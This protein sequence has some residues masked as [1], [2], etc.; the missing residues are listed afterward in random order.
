MRAI[1]VHEP[2]LQASG[3]RSVPGSTDEQHGRLPGGTCQEDFRGS[4]PIPGVRHGAPAGTQRQGDDP[5][6]QDEVGDGQRTGDQSVVRCRSVDLK[7]EGPVSCNSCSRP[8]RCSVQSAK[9]DSWQEGRR[10]RGR[11]GR[12]CL[13]ETAGRKQALRVRGPPRRGRRRSS[14]SR[15]PTS[16]GA[17]YICSAACRSGWRQRRR[18]D[19]GF[20]HGKLRGQ[21]FRIAAAHR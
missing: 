21:P 19:L 14:A 3:S 13:R 2:G 7:G 20:A 11:T 18:A 9:A 16:P 4:V 15:R 10:R 12:R 17:R 8:C 1:S 5:A 6:N